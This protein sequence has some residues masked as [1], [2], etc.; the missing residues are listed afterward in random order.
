MKKRMLAFLLSA[1]CVIGVGSYATV[2]YY[3][4]SSQTTNVLTFAGR[5]GLNAKLTEPNWDSKKGIMLLPNEEIPK[6]PQVTN[7]SDINLDE[8][9]A[10]KVEFVYSD[11]CPQAEKRG[12]ILSDKDMQYVADVY[13]IDYNADGN[14]SAKVWARFDNES[15]KSPVQRFFYMNVLKRN[16]KTTGKGDTTVPLF[17]KIS[18]DKSVN[19][20]RYGHIQDIGGF[21]IIVSGHVI[22]QMTGENYFGLNSGIDAYNHGLFN[23][24]PE[25]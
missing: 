8:L 4:D 10:L 25:Y 22:Q 13:D 12:K 11:A 3:T 23:F 24:K 18:V 21:D 17:T 6:D 9:V 14:S 2:A 20:E 16:L 5:N 1:M 19:N 7:T 15:R